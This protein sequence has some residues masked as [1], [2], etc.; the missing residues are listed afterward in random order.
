MYT[1][2]EFRTIRKKCMQNFESLLEKL[3]IPMPDFESGDEYGIYEDLDRKI[4][5][6]LCAAMK[7]T[8][9]IEGYTNMLNYGHIR[10]SFD[11]SDNAL[12]D[13]VVLNREKIMPRIAPVV[14]NEPKKS[15]STEEIPVDPGYEMRDENQDKFFSHWRLIIFGV[16]F[17]GVAVFALMLQDPTDPSPISVLMFGIS[18]IVGLICMGLGVRNLSKLDTR[19]KKM[20]KVKKRVPIAQT[21][22]S[23]MTQDEANRMFSILD[24]VQKISKKI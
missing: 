13:K 20:V 1:A 16:V 4:T 14:E 6:G 24:D 2:T 9:I 21:V 8:S 18:G 11:E 22:N 23:L 19:N 7:S 17:L 3:K 5:S 10:Y 15:S 12:L